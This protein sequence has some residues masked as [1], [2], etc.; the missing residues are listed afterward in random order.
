MENQ[1]IRIADNYYDVYW[2]F[3]EWDDYEGEF[4][5][6][7]ED[8]ST[9]SEDMIDELQNCDQS[10]NGCETEPYCE[11]ISYGSWGCTYSVPDHFDRP[12][13]NGLE[14]LFGVIE[15]N[16]EVVFLISVVIVTCIIVIAN[17]NKN[18]TRLSSVL[19]ENHEDHEVKEEHNVPTPPTSIEINVREIN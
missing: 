11:E 2:D 6:W 7:A 12:S 17:N 4:L 3:C 8:L 9:L 10:E 15:E 14:S 1:Y 19:I 18:D 16:S 5:C 13:S